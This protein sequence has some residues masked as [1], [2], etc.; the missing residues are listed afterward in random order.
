MKRLL[1]TVLLV[2][3]FGCTTL[4]WT[5]QTITAGVSIG[6]AE[7][8]KLLPSA[9]R[10]V[11]ANYIDV[12][13]SAI[14]KVGGVPTPANLIATINQFIPSNILQAYPELESSVA[15]IVTTLYSQAYAKY[16]GNATKIYAV[17]NDIA[18]GLEAGAAPYI[19]H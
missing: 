17:L 2:P 15:P 10:T 8:L 9:K 1:L 13:A 7:G 19:T 3:L 4:Q 12:Y 16:G 11:I 5:D 6:I 14:R 18:T